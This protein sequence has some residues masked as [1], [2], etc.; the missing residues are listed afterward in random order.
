MS[1]QIHLS[2]HMASILF[3][4][5]ERSIRRALKKK[6]IKFV[7]INSRYKIDLADLIQWSS[8]MPNRRKKRDQDGLGQYVEKWKI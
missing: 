3:G 6:Q 7:V 8:Q 5:S 1:T 4:V 2:P